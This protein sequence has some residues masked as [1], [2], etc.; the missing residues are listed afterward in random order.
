MHAMKTAL[1]EGKRPFPEDSELFR[2]MYLE[3]VSETDVWSQPF[4]IGMR[5]QRGQIY[6]VIGFLRRSN[7]MDSI[8][9]LCSL[10]YT[11]AVPTLDELRDGCDAVLC[12]PKDSKH[13]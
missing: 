2:T 9:K 10:G 1:I 7:M 13:H 8:Q 12:P 5:N 3:S 6:R 4:V 11:E